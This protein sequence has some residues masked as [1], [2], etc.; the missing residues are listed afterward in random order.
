[1]IENL[2]S[3]ID[4]LTNKTPSV[5]NVETT[6]TDLIEPKTSFQREEMYELPQRESQHLVTGVTAPQEIP[7]RS[8]SHRPTRSTMTT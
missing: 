8:S 5:L 3:N 6:E 2:S 7:T 1:M 4:S